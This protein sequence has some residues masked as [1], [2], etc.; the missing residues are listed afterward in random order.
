MEWERSKGMVYL[1]LKRK[2]HKA[3]EGSYLLVHVEEQS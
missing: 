2:G 1:S 3:H